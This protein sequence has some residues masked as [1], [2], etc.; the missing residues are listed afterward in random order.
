MLRHGKNEHLDRVIRNTQIMLIQEGNQCK[1]EW[2]ETQIDKIEQA[3]K[4]NTKFWKHIRMLS[5]SRR[6]GVR[7]LKVR[8][9][10]NIREAKTEAEKTQSF[11]EIYSGLHQI[12]PLEN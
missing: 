7:N 3:A 5:V 4:H 11:T 1:Y 10:G 8:E 12:T 6:A 9:K 2:W